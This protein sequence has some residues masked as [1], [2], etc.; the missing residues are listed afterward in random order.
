MIRQTNTTKLPDFIS[1]DRSLAS[2]EA[3]VHQRDARVAELRRLVKRSK[4][5]LSAASNWHKQYGLHLTL[6]GWSFAEWLPNA[7]NA[8]LIGEFSN[9]KRT[10]QFQLSSDGQ[11][12]WSGLFPKESISHGQQYRLSLD[13][14]GGSGERIPT[15]ATCVSRNTSDI[16]AANVIFNAQVWQPPKK[17][18]WRSRNPG[19]SNLPLIYEAHV[20]MS[21]ETQG[22]STFAEFQ[23]TILPRIAKDGYNTIQLM[24][25]MQHPYYA[26]FGYHVT[27]FFAINDLFGTPE[28]F[29]RLVDAAHALKLRVIIDLVHSHA[30]PNT[31]EG[32]SEMD[33][34]TWLYFHGNERGYHQAWGS[35]C[36]DYGK[37]ELL[38]LLLSNCKFWLEEY[39]LDGFRFDGVTSMLYQD[40]GLNRGSWANGDYF[41]ENVDWDAFAYLS[42]AN[43]LIKEVT[44]DAI[45]IAEEV[46]DI[47]GITSPV[48]GSGLGFDYRLA[49]GVTDYWF[50]L[51]DM[52]D[53][54]W[55]L[56]KLWY[57]L[58]SKR[59]EEKSISYV[60]SHD[61]ALVGGQ[62]FFFKLAG[63]A[64]YKSMSTSASSLVIDR[65]MALH[66][67][68][69]LATFATASNGYLNFMGNEFG[70]PE[71]I[72][73]PTAQ[74]NWSFNYA[75]RQW[76]LADDASLKYHFLGDFDQAMLNLLLLSPNLHLPAPHLILADETRKLLLFFRNNL[77]FAFNFHP[78]QSYKDLEFL[79]F[80]GS[81][82]LV[83]DTDSKRFG[84]FDRIAP[85]QR[86]F[87]VSKRKGNRI[88][89]FISIY[90][91]CRSALVLQLE[92]QR[93]I[94]AQRILPT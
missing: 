67:M 9:W 48:A 59:K 89:E 3:I 75:R 32:L 82:R 60:E 21:Q 81:Y 46:S 64:V 10:K 1:N 79:C 72:D 16:T 70:H 24:G 52:R 29:K 54:D 50:K 51:T 23:R 13:W 19:R 5:T 35:R 53:E 80:P 37:P 76:S 56:G 45:T 91:P 18:A 62:S 93:P 57:E 85:D 36:F 26:S 30:A 8:W 38:N 83:L 92:N 58:T 14:P 63:S 39:H 4:K 90:L 15:A 2:F 87:S 25:V 34:T 33:G 27:N 55:N 66:K 78:T 47:P 43:E 40:H 28:D 71:W 22:I 84:G 6:K 69:R 68:A 7:T 44:P 12:N 42:L 77:L 86:Y 49:M 41:S 73:F 31:V 74:N 20:G 17:F 61:Q 94:S 11:G 88:D 65:A